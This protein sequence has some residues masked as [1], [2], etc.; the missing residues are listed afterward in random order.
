LSMQSNLIVCLLW[1]W[2]VVWDNTMQEIRAVQKNLARQAEGLPYSSYAKFWPWKELIVKQK[3]SKRGSLADFKNNIANWEYL[4]K[5]GVRITDFPSA[6]K[7]LKNKIKKIF[8]DSK[9]LDKS[10][11][12]IRALISDIFV[13]DIPPGLDLKIAFSNILST[14]RAML[15]INIGEGVK[16]RVCD[17]HKFVKKG[18]LNA[19]S[20]FILAGKKSETEYLIKSK[21]ASQHV[22]SHRAI[23]DEKT[24]F[25]WILQEKLK[26]SYYYQSLLISHIKNQSE[27]RITVAADLQQG[28]NLLLNLENDHKGGDNTKGDIAIKA[29]GQQRVKGKIDGFIKIA[30]KATAVDS[31]L[32]QDILLLSPTS[33]IEVQPNLE[34]LN[35]D[36]KASHGAT[37]GYIDENNL[38]YLMSRGFSRQ[39][40][41]KIIADGFIKGLSGRINSEELKSEFL[42]L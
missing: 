19:V 35:N 17:E 2:K 37:L 41:E 39:Q 5:Q 1:R 9:D 40:A 10:E 32:Q 8:A 6:S 21:Q 29:L 14:Y 38:A 23:L 36:V 27:G 20:V 15:F 12:L 42:S 13:I 34:I 25:H 4:E 16:L 33:E 31:F 24:K 28:A 30:K 3:Y 18:T 7:I 11:L 22:F 26:N